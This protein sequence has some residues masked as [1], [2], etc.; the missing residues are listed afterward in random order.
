MYLLLLYWELSRRPADFGLIANL[1]WLSH[2]YYCVLCM[3]KFLKFYLKYFDFLEWYEFKHARYR[4]YSTYIFITML[5]ILWKSEIRLKWLPYPSYSF[6]SIFCWKSR[7]HAFVHP[8]FEWKHYCMDLCSKFVNDGGQRTSSKY[9]DCNF[10]H[11]LFHPWKNW[12]L[13]FSFP[14]SRFRK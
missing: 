11:S 1:F 13:D 10:F 4:C 8:V 14:F 2:V 9:C 7:M 6:L 12:Q 3:S 5:Y